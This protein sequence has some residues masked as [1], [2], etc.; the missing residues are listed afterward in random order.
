MLTDSEFGGGDGRRDRHSL[1]AS[2]ECLRDTQRV[3]L[4]ELGTFAGE[5]IVDGGAPER[6]PS[7][8]VPG[9]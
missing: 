1:Q 7:F 5:E 2:L 3:G 4:C 9:S 6:E 8:E